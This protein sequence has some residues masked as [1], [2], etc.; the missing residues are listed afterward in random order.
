[1][2]ERLQ[3]LRAR[4]EGMTVRERGLLLLVLVAVLYML[5]QAFLLDP[6]LAERK[7]LGQQRSTIQQ[8]IA[9]LRQQAA[10][11]IERHERDPNAPL[12]DRLDALT[13][14]VDQVERQISSEVSDLIAPTQM[15]RVL[16]DL[17]TRNSDLRLLAIENR[18]P[19]PLIPPRTD[20]ADAEDAGEGGQ[21]AAGVFRHGLELRFEGS[22]RETVAYLKAVEAL[23]WGLYWDGLHLELLEYPA[24]RIG[25]RV[26]TLSLEEGWL[27]VGGE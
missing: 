16:E 13:A 7:R 19:R 25:V 17:L 20:S 1:M 8:E 6:L 26:H 22:Y 4:I 23:E 27:G 12:R 2:K 11:T 14:R 5:W 15:S 18:R 21:A 24:V 9:E 10:E 3:Q